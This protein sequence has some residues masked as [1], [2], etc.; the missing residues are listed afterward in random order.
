M[1]F[2]VSRDARHKKEFTP[3]FGAWALETARA[4]DSALLLPMPSVP[5]PVKRTEAITVE[6]SKAGT[7][8]RESVIKGLRKRQFVQVIFWAL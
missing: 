3:I 7:R 2:N 6:I 8:V 5:Q 1:K 4:F